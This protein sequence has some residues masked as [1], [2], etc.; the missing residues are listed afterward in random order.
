MLLRRIPAYPRHCWSK[1]CFNKKLDGLL[2][3]ISDLK[4]EN[5]VLKGTVASLSPSN[6]DLVD[7]TS[8][9]TRRLEDLEAYSR[10]EN[11]IIRGLPE[12]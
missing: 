3:T 12:G 4:R 9:L 8:D 7:V 6:A 5:T 11:V 10:R 1:K 2:H